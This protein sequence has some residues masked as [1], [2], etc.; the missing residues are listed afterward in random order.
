MNLLSDFI[1]HCIFDIDGVFTNGKFGYNSNGKIF[2]LFGAHDHDGLKLLKR[3]NVAI[4]TITADSK[5]YSINK[6]RMDDMNIP[7]ELVSEE[8]RFEWFKS[9][10]D[11]NKIFFMGDSIFDS[12]C[13]NLVYLSCAPANACD[14]AI[15]HADF[16]TKREGGNG[17][18]LEAVQNIFLT[19]KIKLFK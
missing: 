3:N 7:I 1:T 5:G 13:M 12:Q 6:K 17:A 4:T 2:K 14:L 15:S 9:R 19:F 8:N 11:L 16:V 18:V 10:N